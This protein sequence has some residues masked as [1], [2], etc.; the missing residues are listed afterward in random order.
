VPSGGLYVDTSCLLKLFFPEPESPRVVE[1]VE[2]EERV[3]VSELALLESAVQIHARRAGGLLTARDAKLLEA[4]L[5]R[6]VQT[7]PFS[8]VPV[9]PEALAVAREQA[10]RMRKRI[11]CRTLDRLHLGIMTF[12]GLRRLC[13][14]DDRQATD[15]RALGMRVVV[16]RGARRAG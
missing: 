15:A 3:V 14:N 12:E 8:V 11:V 5:E 6:M 13:T 7:E 2:H 10:R 4:R 16:P 9:A 1:L